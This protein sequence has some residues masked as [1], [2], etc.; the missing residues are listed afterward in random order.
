MPL[1]TITRSHW[2]VYFVRTRHQALYCGIT[3]DV[4]RRFAQHCAGKGAKA[5]VGKGPLTLEWFHS[6]DSGRAVA[7]RVEYQLKQLKKCQKESL[8][9]GLTRLEILNDEGVISIKLI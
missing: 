6:V 7:S 5:L 4:E 9:S 3:N 8:V 1:D 2:F